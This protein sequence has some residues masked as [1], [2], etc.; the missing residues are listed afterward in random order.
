MKKI[1]LNIFIFLSLL[2]GETV[3]TSVSGTVYR[4]EKNIPLQGADVIF[5]NLNGDTFGAST[6]S[7][8]EYQISNIPSG[9]YN[10]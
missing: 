1:F 10:V 7:Q 9:K 6:D 5:I 3:E 2:S 4:S 8:G